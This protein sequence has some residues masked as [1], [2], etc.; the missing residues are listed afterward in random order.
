MDAVVPKAHSDTESNRS[1]D[2]VVPEIDGEDV[3]AAKSSAIIPMR[4][5]SLPVGFSSIILV[6]HGN[7][8]RNN[9]S[10]THQGLTS[11][12]KVQAHRVGKFLKA[13]I[14]PTKFYH[15]NMTRSMETAKII[16]SY[17]SPTPVICSHLLREVAFNEIG[18]EPCS[19]VYIYTS[20]YSMT[21]ISL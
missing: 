20:V 18:V 21:K 5:A 13:N 9:F 19:K 16:L 11:E 6:R 10:D 8:V 7:Y 17:F 14:S 4:P 1:Q 2:Q 15:S 3:T 12:G